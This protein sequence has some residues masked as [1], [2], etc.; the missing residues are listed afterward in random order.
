MALIETLG[1]MLAVYLLAPLVVGIPIV[2]AQHWVTRRV[3]IT[4]LL[5]QESPEIQE[6]LD[7]R[8]EAIEAEGFEVQGAYRIENFTANVTTYFQLYLHSETGLA[9]MSV[10]VQSLAISARYEEISQVFVNGRT[11]NVNN[12]RFASSWRVPLREV[13]R[14]PWLAAFSDLLKLHRWLVAQNRDYASEGRP[15]PKDDAIG[16]LSEHMNHELVVQA[17]NGLYQASQD[18][19]NWILTWPGAVHMVFVNAFPGKQLLSFKELGQNR[20]L[21]KKARKAGAL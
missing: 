13:R 20:D 4:P 7:S 1:G 15:F 18:G 2:K 3:Q 5:E 11:L 9:A 17:Q 8:R 12:S 10:W 14:F 19:R 6:W 21:E 16:Y